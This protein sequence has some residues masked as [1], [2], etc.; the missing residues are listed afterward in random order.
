MNTV[1]YVHGSDELYGSDRCLL[2]IV[3]SIGGSHRALVVLPID[4]PPTG[5]LTTELERAGATVR[6]TRMLVLRRSGLGW[7]HLPSMLTSFIAGVWT[8]TRMIRQEDVSLVHSNTVAVVCGVVAA[9]ITRRPHLWHVHEFLGDEPLPFRVALRLLLRL[10]PGSVVANSRAVARAS[11]VPGAIVIENAV[12]LDVPAPTGPR[13]SEGPITI[14]YVGRLSERK[15]IRQAI[16]AV[17]MLDAQGIPFQFLVAGGPPPG[18]S[19][20]RSHYELLAQER[21]VAGRTIFLGEIDDPAS[22]YSRMDILLVPSQRP[23][24]F[25]LTIVEGMAAG[26]AVVATRN[27]GGSDEILD[28]EVTGLYCATDPTSI[29]A[30]LQRVIAHEELRHALG[31]RAR[32]VA[33]TRFNRDRY[34]AD[35]LKTYS[36]LEA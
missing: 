34:V 26:C 2:E 32:Q 9:G 5:Q 19:A 1:L 24:P 13:T 7:R 29:A 10:M 31:Q 18:Q 22:V 33:S 23:E 11:N 36:L 27:G 30:A 20:L 6:R 12:F 21:G 25:G 16:E 35:M 28:D 8:L 14:G 3:Q 17:A 15:G 4:A